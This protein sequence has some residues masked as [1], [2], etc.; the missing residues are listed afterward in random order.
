MVSQLPVESWKVKEGEKEDE[1][2]KI[3]CGRWVFRCTAFNNKESTIVLAKKCSSYILTGKR[4]LRAFL[5]VHW[6][7]CLSFTMQLATLDPLEC[8]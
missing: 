2:T 7:M 3:S 6:I 1:G 4:H 8:N 5:A